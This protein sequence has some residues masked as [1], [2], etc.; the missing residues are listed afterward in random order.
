MG[1]PWIQKQYGTRIDQIRTS[2]HEVQRAYITYIVTHAVEIGLRSKKVTL[3]E[4]IALGLPE[5]DPGLDPHD[6]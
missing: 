2:V 6:F 1:S 5:S 4:L 3:A